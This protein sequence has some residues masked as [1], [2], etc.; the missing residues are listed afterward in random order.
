MA[1][2]LKKSILKGTLILTAAGVIAR[3]LGFYNRIF[4]CNLFGERE[5]GIYQMILPVYMVIFSLCCQGIQTALTRQ[6]GRIGQSATGSEA[7]LEHEQ[8]KRQFL[9]TALILSFSL[10]LICS[11]VL[12]I[13]S[14]FISLQILHSYETTQCIKLLSLAIPFVSVKGCLIGYFIGEERSGVTAWGQLIEQI[15]KISGVYLLSSYILSVTPKAYFA[16]YGIILGEI[17]SCGFMAAAYLSERRKRNGT[18]GASVQSIHKAAKSGK[19]ELVELLKDALPLTT[20]RLSLTTLQS[21]ES[22]LIPH[23]LNLYLNNGDAALILYGTLTGLVLPCIM[24]PTTLT[25]SLATMLLPAISAQYEAHHTQ[26]LQRMVKKSVGFCLAIGICSAIFLLFFG[27]WTGSV[28]LSSDTAGELLFQFAL[29]CPFIYLSACLAS[30]MN[31]LGK[32]T[33]NMLHSILCI[34]IRIACILC[35]VPTLG[36]RGYMWGM[37]GSYLLQTGLLLLSIHRSIK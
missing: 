29:L 33:Q 14:D 16:V 35:M 10:S 18:S 26:A 7:F 11:I 12:F 27:K 20:N 3:I 13:C 15:T 2:S 36:L 28:L 21:L 23:M 25:T 22:I 9:K 32:A 8:R 31:G 17:F 30:I 6:I 19:S 24:F 37:M 5:L 4:L 1:S 34:G